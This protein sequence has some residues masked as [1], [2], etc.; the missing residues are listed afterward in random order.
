MFG[1]GLIF[2][3]IS[4][5]YFLPVLGQRLKEV[6]PTWF[7]NEAAHSDP[8]LNAGR[9]ITFTA[10]PKSTANRLN[11]THVDVV[12]SNRRWSRQGTS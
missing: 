2:W 9:W 12:P 10:Q 6:R 8:N 11:E 7:R 1:A 5:T 3:C 4:F